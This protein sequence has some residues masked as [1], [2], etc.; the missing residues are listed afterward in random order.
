MSTIIYNIIMSKVIPYNCVLGFKCLCVSSTSAVGSAGS[1]VV[2]NVYKQTGN[3]E[4]NA[5][6][7]ITACPKALMTSAIKNVGKVKNRYFMNDKSI[8]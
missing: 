2:N 5:K 6:T 8:G 3:P 7:K 4:L 1:V